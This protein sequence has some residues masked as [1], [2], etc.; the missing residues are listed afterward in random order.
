MAEAALA[1]A[2]AGNNDPATA[3]SIKR[4]RESRKELCVF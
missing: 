2:A 4:L 3:K 1:I